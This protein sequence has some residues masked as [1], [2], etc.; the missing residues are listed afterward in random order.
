MDIMQEFDVV[1]VVQVVIDGYGGV[2]VFVNN[3]GFGMY[4]LV[5]EIGIDDVCYQFEVNF[6]GMV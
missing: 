4:G 5:E 6:F 1:V 3:V 2:D